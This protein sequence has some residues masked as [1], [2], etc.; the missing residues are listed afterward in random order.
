MCVGFGTVFDWLE[1]CGISRYF[2]GISRFWFR[3]KRT[4]FFRVPYMPVFFGCSGMVGMVPAF[5]PRCAFFDS[6]RMSGM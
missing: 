4:R 2:R 1:I 6:I 5:F 3:L